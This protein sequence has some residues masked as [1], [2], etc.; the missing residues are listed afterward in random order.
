MFKLEFLLPE[1]DELVDECNSYSE[2]ITILPKNV[3]VV[4]DD[5]ILL[6]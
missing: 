4:D 5:P 3:L 2:S 1:T 6:K